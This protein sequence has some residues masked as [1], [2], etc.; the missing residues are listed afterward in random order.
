MFLI[1]GY[2]HCLLKFNRYL[3][4]M[5]TKT[6]QN[7]KNE[8]LCI[9]R[10]KIIRCSS[11]IQIFRVDI[12]WCQRHINI[13][14]SNQWYNIYTLDSPPSSGCTINI[15]LTVYTGHTLFFLHKYILSFVFWFM[16]VVICQEMSIHEKLKTHIF[17]IFLL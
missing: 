14:C 3:A 8:R 17:S 15:S 4:E 13:S 9:C 11:H 2:N 7:N 5:Q 10:K 6:T 12:I 1:Y 16:C